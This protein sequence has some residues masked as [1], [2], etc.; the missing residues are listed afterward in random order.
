MS[1]MD[2]EGVPSAREDD[3]PVHR[4]TDVAKSKMDSARKR[5]IAPTVAAEKIA[6]RSPSTFRIAK[7]A[8]AFS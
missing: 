3:Q 2:D 7:Q 8:G 1:R 6:A 4:T 5:W